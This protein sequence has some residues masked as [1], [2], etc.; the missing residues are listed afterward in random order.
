MERIT[1]WAIANLDR[2]RTPAA[3]SPWELHSGIPLEWYTLSENLYRAFALTGNAKYRE[4]ADVW[5]YDAYWNRFAET[6]R[7]RGA[8]GVHAQ[9]R[10]PFSGAWPCA[11]SWTASRGCSPS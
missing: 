7:P 1:D 4:F 8:Q 11:I 2:T 10:E 9:P 6:G 3:N 5:N